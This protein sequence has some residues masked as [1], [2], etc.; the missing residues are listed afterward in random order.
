MNKI[1][2]TCGTTLNPDT[3]FCNNCGN[4]I[5]DNTS[6]RNTGKFRHRLMF[7]TSLLLGFAIIF[8]F[9]LNIFGNTYKKPIKITQQMANGD[10]GNLEKIAPNEYWTSS[11]EKANKNVD[12]FL[13]HTESSL[14]NHYNQET[15]KKLSEKY[16]E[17]FTVKVK[18][19]NRYG[20]LEEDGLDLLKENLNNNYKI[21]EKSVKS[22][23][24]VKY[25]FKASGS[26]ATGSYTKKAV[27][28]KIGNKWY[29]TNRVG[30]LGVALLN[31]RFLL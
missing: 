5:I 20:V 27:M 9:S 18:N 14:L 6:R 4:G 12:D 2:P 13:S 19:I 15:A 8:A 10:F 31:W 16:G 11:A 21:K 24:L 1:C 28:V 22:A 25:T 26:K 17:N 23:I 29:L 3:D 30:N 7:F